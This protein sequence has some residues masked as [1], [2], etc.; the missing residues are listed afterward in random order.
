MD[1]L[2]TQAIDIVLKNDA[3]QDKIIEPLKRKF[4]P[5][6]MCF[7]LFNLAIFIM[8]AQLTN[9]LSAIL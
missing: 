9:Q 5:Y 2:T 8:I 1:D 3:L 6:L 4:F 7:T